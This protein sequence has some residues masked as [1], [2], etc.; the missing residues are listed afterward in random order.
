MPREK[1][2]LR[3]VFSTTLPPFEFIGIGDGSGYDGR[4]W[5]GLYSRSSSESQQYARLKYVMNLGD[6]ASRDFASN[7]G[8]SGTLAHETTHIWQYTHGLWVAFDSAFAQSIGDGYEYE[9]QV[10]PRVD[11]DNNVARKVN[12]AP[13]SDFNVEQQAHIVEDWVLGGQDQNDIRFKYIEN[14]IRKGKIY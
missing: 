11:M 2:L 13:W 10:Q 7:I 12:I 1:I 5:T 9:L 8:L 14:N 4:E 3:N 6:N